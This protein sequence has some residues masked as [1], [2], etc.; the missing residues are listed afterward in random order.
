LV[1]S[2]CLLTTL[3]EIVVDPQTCGI[4]YNSLPNPG[5]KDQQ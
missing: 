2:I 3:L 4:N 1:L 5:C